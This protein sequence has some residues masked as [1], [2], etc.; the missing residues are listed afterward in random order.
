MALPRPNVTTQTAAEYKVTIDAAVHL[1]GGHAYQF[2][3]TSPDVFTPRRVTIR[4]GT[5]LSSGVNT[6]LPARQFDFEK[7]AAPDS[8][9]IFIGMTASSGEIVSAIGN[10]PPATT[11][12]DLAGPHALRPAGAIPLARIVLPASE[13]FVHQ[14]HIADERPIFVPTTLGAGTL[15]STMVISNLTRNS[16]VGSVID[17][18][19]SMPAGASQAIIRF[20]GAG[21]QGADGNINGLTAFSG[22]A[23]R[24]TTAQSVIHIAPGGI[25][26][27]NLE[28]NAPPFRQ[29]IGPRLGAEGGHGGRSGS[30]RGVSGHPS[31]MYQ[32]HLFSVDFPVELDVGASFNTPTSA[33]S[34]GGQGAD[35]EATF[36]FFT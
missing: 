1:L 5:L 27:T 24:I 23:S 8:T 13:E 15:V 26:G 29:P 12:A 10:V 7:E 35:G 11:P 14:T 34:P 20:C 2:A 19:V 36:Y 28:S 4:P 31:N 32:L 9:L 3:V 16:A 18:T 17:E 22:G 30:N 25:G 33:T 6:P 21:G